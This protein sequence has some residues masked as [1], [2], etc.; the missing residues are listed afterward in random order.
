MIYD[1]SQSRQ[2]APRINA[3]APARENYAYFQAPLFLPPKAIFASYEAFYAK[4]K[5]GRSSFPAFLL[6]SAVNPACERGPIAN[7][8]RD[9]IILKLPRWPSTRPKPCG[10]TL[11]IPFA[12][13]GA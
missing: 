2:N 6:P 4:A 8:Q 13:P 10:K 3:A 12:P 7:N 1:G 5:P 11:H 9:L